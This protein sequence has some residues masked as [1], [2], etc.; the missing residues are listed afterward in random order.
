MQ[1]CIYEEYGSADVVRLGEVETPALESGELLVEVHAAAVTTADWRFRSSSFP[2]LFWLPGRLMVG[3]L[4]PRKPVLG[5]DFS[6]VVRATAPGVK[7]FRAGDPVFGSTA[8]TRLGA[9]AELVAL[10]ESAAIT[11]K[12]S[13]L[14]HAEAAA[15]PFGANAALA[16]LRDFG[17]VEPGQRVLV[18]GASG[19]VGVWAVQLARELGAEVTG[20]CSSANVELVRSLGAHRVVNYEASDILRPGDG[21]DLVFDTVGVTT[22]RGSRKA[23]SKRGVYLP[24]TGG[25]REILQALATAGSRGQKVKI[26]VS[27]NTRES[28]ETIVSMIEGGRVRPVVDGVYP[29]HRIQDAHRRVE[30]RHKRGSV[31]V[32]MARAA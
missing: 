24:L 22:F 32:E 4:R 28:L 27:Q 10:P 30:G 12:P 19:N 3:L 17:R 25:V 7:R 9:H 31:I 5:M 29:M 13:R 18:V 8:A 1:A 11:H 6:G 20:V 16:F 2:G 21:Y 26:G 14:S 15:I 23:L